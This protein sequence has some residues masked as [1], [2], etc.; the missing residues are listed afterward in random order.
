MHPFLYLKSSVRKTSVHSFEL[1][2]CA[3]LKQ[4]LDYQN[5]QQSDSNL[6]KKIRMYLQIK[7]PYL[8]N[9]YEYLGMGFEN[10]MVE[11]KV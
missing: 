3:I 11:R 2:K 8:N 10:E 9:I 5:Q 7:D 4:T 1:N 6:K